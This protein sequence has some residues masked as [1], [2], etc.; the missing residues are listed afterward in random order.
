M[1]L[2]LLSFADEFCALSAL[3][4]HMAL[5]LDLHSHMIELLPSKVQVEE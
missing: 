2:E 4:E 1:L 5:L 3:W